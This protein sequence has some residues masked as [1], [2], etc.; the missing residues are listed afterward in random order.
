MIR[1]ALA[2]AVMHRNYLQHSPIQIIRY[3]NR[4]EIRNV[5]HS[6]KPISELGM[7]GS[8]PRN[9]TLAAVLH[10]L[11]LAEAKGTG[12][13]TMR[14]LAAEAGLTLPE[15]NSSRESDDFRATLFLHN[16]LTEDDHAWLRSL[17]AEPLDAEEIKVLIY[18]RATG[19]V[20]N[21]A[22]RDFSGLDTLAASRV[23]RRL[24]DRGLLDKQ[25]GG[26]RTHYELAPLA[27]P[28]AGTANLAGQLPNEDPSG[29]AKPY[30]DSANPH[31]KSTESPD[32]LHMEIPEPLRLR[33]E[34]A[35]K[36][37]RQPVLPGLIRD[38]CALRPFTAAELSALL[39][40]RDAGELKRLH[41]KPMREIGE[42]NLLY[43]ESEKHRY[44]AYVM[45]GTQK[46]SND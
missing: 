41:L 30:G 37:P 40:G 13:R 28:P 38:L 25:G 33:I 8:K 26:S 1:E 32:E 15:F 46:V 19:A 14:R 4:I 7:P 16:L 21:T 17:T 18:V 39:G 11:N 5:G 27:N 43:P 6:L 23:L 44:Q 22:C 2:N 36:K 3:S 35:G 12:I 31:M 45:P 34:A 20:D 29:Q 10:D 42:L 24:R 9:P